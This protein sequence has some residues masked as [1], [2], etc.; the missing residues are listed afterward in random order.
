MSEQ[1]KAPIVAVDFTFPEMTTLEK[2]IV[3][4]LAEAN[5]KGKAMTQAGVV[6]L[7]KNELKRR[8]I[9]GLDPDTVLGSLENKRVISY[10]Y[11]RVLG[12]PYCVIEVSHWAYQLAVAGLEKAT[13]AVIK[14]DFEI[15]RECP[16]DTVKLDRMQLIQNVHTILGGSR[17]LMFTNTRLA[18][19]NARLKHFT[20]AQIYKAAENLAKS[21]W[22]MG[23][24][25]N[26]KK[27]ATVD[28]LLRSDE[29]VEEWL[30]SEDDKRK[31]GQ[32]LDKE[33]MEGV[34]L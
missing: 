24:N 6:I 27:Y 23:R 20:A 10:S 2:R 13:K 17:A 1:S 33:A 4:D 30:Y 19:A 32:Q 11:R 8:K 16:A 21:E 18:H 31:I 12:R 26:G 9:S 14:S 25:P 34:F 28:F 7:I 3:L 29:K 5:L 22:H 15:A